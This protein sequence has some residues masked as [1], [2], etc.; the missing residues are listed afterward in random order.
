MQ[1]EDKKQSWDDVAWERLKRGFV[2]ARRTL[3]CIAGA[4]MSLW[5][6]LLMLLGEDS[7]LLLFRQNIGWINIVAQCMLPFT[8]LAL[9]VFAVVHIFKDVP[10]LLLLCA[11]A[12][13]FYS[14]RLLA[15]GW[16]PGLLV[17]FAGLL[18][19]A[20]E[21]H[22]QCSL[23]KDV[24]REKVKSTMLVIAG[25]LA[26]L[27]SAFHVYRAADTIIS[28]TGYSEGQTYAF[29]T[30]LG[31]VVGGICIA[32]ACFMKNRPISVY[33]RMFFTGSV[34]IFILQSVLSIVAL[35]Q[36]PEVPVLTY[37][38]YFANAILAVAIT[39]LVV[40]QTIKALPKK[41]APPEDEA[42]EEVADETTDETA[43]TDA[44]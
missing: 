7:L 33:Y 28:Q 37:I 12:S 4:A 38:N 41:S 20:M 6:L 14:I 44:E 15:I 40:I 43:E 42:T 35:L 16:K 32:V 39:A 25:V 23:L 11:G 2:R 29:F 17:L 26:L 1:T 30:G 13:A 36:Y 18:L 31:N 3:A 21:A 27:W 10:R 5:A 8:M 19:F 22:R 24:P 34:A 9:T